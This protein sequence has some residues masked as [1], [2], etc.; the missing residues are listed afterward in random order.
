MKLDHVAIG[1]GDFEK[2]L[3]LFET[4][5]GVKVV[6]R[7]TI[8]GTTTNIA[9]VQE[10]ESLG[11][12]EVIHRKTNNDVTLEHIAFRVDNVDEKFAELRKQGFVVEREP[13]DIPTAKARSALLRDSTGLC[14]QLIAYF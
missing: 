8:P 12:M 1:V 14:I 11:Q 5:F 7:S 3:K 9:L 13:H 2:V 10:P 4:H 6:R